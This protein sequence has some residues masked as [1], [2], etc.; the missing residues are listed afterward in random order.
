MV[1]PPV[2]HLDRLVHCTI[3]FTDPHRP[4]MLEE[5][6]QH[7]EAVLSG[8]AAQNQAVLNS[9][10]LPLAYDHRSFSVNLRDLWLL[11]VNPAEHR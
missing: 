7:L 1:Q 5:Q 10:H 8:P 4:L 6:Q 2:Y 11:V 9:M 3:G